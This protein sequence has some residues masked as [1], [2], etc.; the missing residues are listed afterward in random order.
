VF[1]CDVGYVSFSWIK[2]DFAV[3]WICLIR[4][5]GF[6]FYSCLVDVSSAGFGGG[7][8]VGVWVGGGSFAYFVWVYGWF[9]ILSLV[10]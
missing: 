10:V 3:G 7:V 5:C 1:A 9:W 4:S 8:G 2:Y 6:V